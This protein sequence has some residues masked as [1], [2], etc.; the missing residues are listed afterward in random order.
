M[1]RELPVLVQQK[2]QGVCGL[3][4][5]RAVLQVLWPMGAV[6]LSAHLNKTLPLVIAP[7]VVWGVTAPEERKYWWLAVPVAQTSEYPSSL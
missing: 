7:G 6:R 5:A 2:A 3:F 4:T 1:G